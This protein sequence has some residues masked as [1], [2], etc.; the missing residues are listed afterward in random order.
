MGLE[1]LAELKGR[2]SVE[3]KFDPS[4]AKNKTYK[5]THSVVPVVLTISRLQKLFPIAFPKNP[6]PKVPLKVGIL[7]DLEARAEEIGLSKDE[8][9]LAIKTWC[10][11]PRYW[12]V[13][14]VGA[15]R[16][17]L[18]GNNAGEVEPNGAGQAL[19]MASKYKK[20]KQSVT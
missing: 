1:K 2:L 15:V 6:T 18:D 13:V 7:S 5:H 9:R 20:A 8:L 11:S 12:S 17:D 16:Y 10:K 14:K 19:A 4:N 3:S